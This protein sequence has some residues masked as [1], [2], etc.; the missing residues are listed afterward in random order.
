M[1]IEKWTAK[2]QEAIQKAITMASE[3]GHQVV[4]V[5]HFLLALLE[6]SAG[7]LYRV[8]SRSNVDIASLQNKLLNRLQSKPVVSN[9]DINSIRISYDLNQLIN[10]SDKQMH[11]FKDEYLSV[12]H[13][14]MALFELNSSWIKDLLNEYHLNRKD[15]KKVIDEMR[16]DNMVNNQNPE[17]QYEV[18]ESMVV[19]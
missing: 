4:D 6:D 2:M 1:N 11:K 12:E 7:I 8:L 19:I 17:N 13:L 15:V 14:I 10:L 18:L 5:E 9:V 3:K 16:G